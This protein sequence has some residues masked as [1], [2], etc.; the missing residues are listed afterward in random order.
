MWRLNRGYTLQELLLATLL[1]SFIFLGLW[2]VVSVGLRAQGQV[3]TGNELTRQADYAMQRMI[4]SVQNSHNLILPLA[5]NPA[6]NWPEHIRDQT[7][8]PSAPVG[9]S[10]FASAVLA[11]S[12]PHASDRDGDGWSDANNDKDFQDDN[13]NGIRDPGE[14][15]RIDEDSG[16]D[17]SNDGANGIVGIDDNGDGSVDNGA[18]PSAGVRVDDDEDGA[19]TED[20]VNGIDDDGDGSIDEDSKGDMNHDAEPGLAGVDDD[21]DGS[22][23]EGIANDDDEDGTHNEDWPDTVAFYLSGTKLIER[24]PSLTDQNGDS[25]INGKD[26]VESVLADNV[27]RFRVERMAVNGA[28]KQLL[29]LLLELRD[30]LST[31]TVSLRTKVRLGGGL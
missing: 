1:A 23:D 11:L 8:P 17:K 9:D 6:T 21:G 15:E 3:R 12:L 7:I 5:D 19:G 26:F 29:D 14:L 31:E 24:Q 22:V 13:N 2:Q 30:P 20:P 25:V 27:S 4:Q 16:A 10:S 28:A 18:S